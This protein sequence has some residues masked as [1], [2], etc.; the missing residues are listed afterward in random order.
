MRLTGVVWYQGETNYGYPVQY[1]CS[2]PAM[3]Y[4]WREKFRLP[5]M[6]FL[7]VQLAP[8]TQLGNFV[9]LRAAQMAALKLPRVGYAVAVDI[10]DLESP[11]GSIHPR[12]KQEVGRRLSLEAR[13][14]QYGETKLVSTGPVLAAVAPGS[15]NGTLE[16]TYAAGTAI[17]LH[18]APTADCGKIGSMLCCGESP[19]QVQTS[20]GK[21]VRAN[22]TIAGETV[23]LGPLAAGAVMKQP[24]QVQY[25]WEQWP[26][27]SVYNGAGGCDDHQG[28]AGTPWCVSKKC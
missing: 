27:C 20:A 12:R 24:A 9:G 15:A 7:F 1:S 18:V 4:D 14:L 21:W 10:G 2:F 22:F 25:A 23:V 19:F 5:Q 13:R 16:V 11:M 8:S 6:L 26:Q 17:G 28:I 3:I